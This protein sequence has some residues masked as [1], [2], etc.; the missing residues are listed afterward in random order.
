M[1]PKVSRCYSDRK[2][3]TDTFISSQGAQRVH[4][5][6]LVFPSSNQMIE[7]SLLIL[8][9]VMYLLPSNESIIQRAFIRTSKFLR[10]SFCSITVHVHRHCE[11]KR[12]EEFVP[13]CWAQEDWSHVGFKKH[14]SSVLH[15]LSHP[16]KG[17]IALAFQSF[18]QE[19]LIEF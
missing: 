15:S 18:I 3:R 5:N 7:K 10:S 16:F 6:F 19:I 12:Y 9:P 2:S 11:L 8:K 4:R 1:S 13:S 14:R 17:K